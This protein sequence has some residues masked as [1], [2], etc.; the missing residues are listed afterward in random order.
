V[1][2]EDPTRRGA[3][4]RRE[5]EPYGMHGVLACGDHD[6]LEHAYGSAP[7][8][9]LIDTLGRSHPGYF[10]HRLRHL[11]RQMAA[12]RAGVVPKPTG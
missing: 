1:V 3:G 12:A 7:M 4:P 11:R 6:E 9:R 2:P 8:K 10:A 5:S